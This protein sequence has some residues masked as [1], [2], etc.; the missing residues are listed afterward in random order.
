[1]EVKIL[2]ERYSRPQMKNN[3]SESNTFEL[4]LSIEIAACQAWSDQGIIPKNDM[5]KIR[6]AKFEINLYNDQNL[7]KKCD[8]DKIT[9]TFNV[10]RTGK[11]G[12]DANA[13]VEL[14]VDKNIPSLLYYTLDTL[15]ESDIPLVKK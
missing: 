13:K 3:W 9:E 14:R 15:E 7:T 8:T 11:A 1:M 6:N 5:Q 10:V 12:V 2:I 4:W